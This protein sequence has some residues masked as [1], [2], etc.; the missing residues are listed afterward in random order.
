MCGRLFYVTN[1]EQEFVDGAKLT[2]A[3]FE[4]GVLGRKSETSD[5]NQRVRF[6]KTRRHAAQ[7]NLIR[8][9]NEMWSGSQLLKNEHVSAVLAGWF[10]RNRRAGKGQGETPKL[11]AETIAA[12][13]SSP[14]PSVSI[15]QR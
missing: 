4:G 13:T 10:N 2:A 5:C 15:L 1:H 6:G 8:Y 14:Q 3:A 12:P 9:G 11:D 7:R